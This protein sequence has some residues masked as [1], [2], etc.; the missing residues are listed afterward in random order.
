MNPSNPDLLDSMFKISGDMYQIYNDK[1]GGYV[2][3][4]IGEDVRLKILELVEMSDIKW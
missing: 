4:A 2:N 3:F 1:F